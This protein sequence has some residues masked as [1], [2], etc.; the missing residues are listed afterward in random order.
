MNQGVSQ[1][2]GGQKLEA[3]AI[4]LTDTSRGTQNLIYHGWSQSWPR[5]A[6]HISFHSVRIVE[7]SCS[8]LLL[9]LSIAKEVVAVFS[10]PTELLK[11]DRKYI[12]SE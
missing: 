2:Q 7:K 8:H 6:L 9:S 10:V 12:H 1:R 5:L 4:L 3:V 11:M